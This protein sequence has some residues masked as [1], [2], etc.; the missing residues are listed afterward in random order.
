MS[1]YLVILF[2]HVLGAIGI[3]VG[4]AL[5]GFV[6]MRLRASATVDEVRFYARA[7]GRLRV[8]FIPS[9]L[10]VLVGGLYLGAVVGNKET[11]WIAVGLGGTLL[12]MAIGITMNAVP[13]SR[14]NRTLK[15]ATSMTD[16][17]GSIG[18][19]GMLV[20][21]G[22]RLGI[23]LGIVFVMTTKCD[24][25]TSLAAVAVSCASCLALVLLRRR[26]DAGS[27]RLRIRPE[28]SPRFGIPPP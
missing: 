1:L 17:A 3:F 26:S 22:M 19:Q 4:L 25:V 11:L 12:M 21:Y 27:R 14:L 15:S 16:V 20:S 23:A 13:L 24:L 6:T 18:R 28:K 2:L 8:L 7:V 5:E 9:F 10:G